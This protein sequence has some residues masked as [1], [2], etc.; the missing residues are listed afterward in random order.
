M[1]HHLDNGDQHDPDNPDGPPPASSPRLERLVYGLGGALL[2]V[3]VV[4]SLAWLRGTHAD[5]TA[6]RARGTAAAASSVA[7]ANNSAA[8]KLAHQVET[9]GG[10]PIVQPSQ[11][12][13]VKGETGATGPVGPGPSDSQVQ[14]AVTAYCAPRDGCTGS[15]SSAQV[16]AAVRAYCSDGTCTGPAG[17]NATG[18]AGA[19]GTNGQNGAAG[20]QGPGPSDAQ[21]AAAV[22][23][24]CG[25]HGQCAGA[26]G[27]D[28]TDGQNGTNGKDGRGIAAVD[29]S[30]LIPTDT[31]TIHYD[32]GSTQTV[33]CTPP[34][35]G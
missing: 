16:A 14:A 21:V 28:G 20:A 35:G 15:P 19:A 3:A 34:A 1:T 24:Y 27:A 12:P 29:C 31:F 25:T 33:T 22:D 10:T 6:S 5:Q 7:A 18:A 2:A 23:S 9:L 30:A 11:L 4:A 26:P 8:Q 17:R 32:D 13:T